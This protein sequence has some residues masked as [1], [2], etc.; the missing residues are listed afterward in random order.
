MILTRRILASLLVGAAVL[1]LSPGA[2]HAAPSGPPVRIGGSLALTGPLGAQGGVHKIVGE[3]YVEQLNR[4]DGLRGRPVEYVLLD[5]QSKPE[6]ARSLYE[7]LIT[8]DKVDLVIGAFATGANLA[9]M[10]VAQRYGKMLISN[11]MGVPKLGTYEMHFPVQ[12]MPPDPERTFMTTV[13]DALASTGTSP[14]T[15]A[16]VASKF[17]SV[18]FISTGAREVAE[19]RGIAIPLYLEYEFGLRDF[20]PIA[21]RVKEVNADFL[22]IGAV[23]VESKML[24]EA[25]KTIGYAPRGHFSLFP[26]S[27]PLVVAP[28]GKFHLS[29][30]V[31]EEHAPFTSN[32][33]TADFVKQFNERAAKAGLPYTKVEQQAGIAYTAWQVLEAAIAG[34][35]S[36]D[37]KVLARWLKA[38]RVDTIIG[39]QR[40]DGFNNFGDD[41]YRVR[42][43]QGDRWLV[44]WPREWAAPGAKLVYPNP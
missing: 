20:G 38:N 2:P 34:S 10:A 16:I 31:F 18:H 5:D 3:I 23:G 43:I 28:E 40:F 15:M 32:P 25:L 37:D 9:A 27:G 13:L 30:T 11:S 8:V 24:L 39:K 36:L 12:G 6:V 19:K 17:P 21:A 14:K 1:S 4:K 42:Q 7:R 41:L 26:A 29:M 33:A 44:V 35:K 22:W